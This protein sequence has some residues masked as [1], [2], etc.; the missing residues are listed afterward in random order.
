MNHA[1]YQ[2]IIDQAET[3][4]KKLLAE[5]VDLRYWR[6]ELERFIAS[7]IRLQ[8]SLRFDTHMREKDDVAD[9]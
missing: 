7:M 1:D 3:I 5:N 6:H 8:E 9:S 2:Q 4:R